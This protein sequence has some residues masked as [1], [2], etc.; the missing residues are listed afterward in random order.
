M[1]C[2]VNEGGHTLNPANGS[3]LL[4]RAIKTT[5]D[6]RVRSLPPV[7]SVRKP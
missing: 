4:P 1:F 3:D 2:Y 7:A 5:A 6:I